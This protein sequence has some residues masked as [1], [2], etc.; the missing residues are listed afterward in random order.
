MSLKQQAEKESELTLP[1][2]ATFRD[3]FIAAMDDVYTNL[4]IERKID[5]FDKPVTMHLERLYYDCTDAIA[6]YIKEK[7]SK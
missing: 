3:E 4:S 7:K 6:V 2:L 5:F 1:E